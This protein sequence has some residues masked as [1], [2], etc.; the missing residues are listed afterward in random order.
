M[1][2]G[3]KP[4][5]TSRRKRGSSHGRPR[6]PAPRNPNPGDGTLFSR[7]F[8]CQP[9]LLPSTNERVNFVADQALSPRFQ[10]GYVE[11]Q[12]ESFQPPNQQFEAHPGHQLSSNSILLCKIA[13]MCAFGS[14][15]VWLMSNGYY[16]YFFCCFQVFSGVVCFTICRCEV[17]S[18]GSLV[19][20]ISIQ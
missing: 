12:N 8:R 4:E 16:Y 19:V 5:Y 18:L 2:R 1:H 6:R 11:R 7:D 9:S 3:R 20:L 13:S 17:S 10:D 15:F 14:N